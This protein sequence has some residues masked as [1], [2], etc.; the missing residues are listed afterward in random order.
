MAASN[1]GKWQ[2]GPY[3]Y[4]LKRGSTGRAGGTNSGPSGR[5]ASR[6]M[7]QIAKALGGGKGSTPQV[8]KMHLAELA[9]AKKG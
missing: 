9:A 1:F 2:G 6:F 5:R 3:F 4:M 8:R 7:Y